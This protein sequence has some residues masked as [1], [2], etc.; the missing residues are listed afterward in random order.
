[1]IRLLIRNQWKQ[2][3]RNYTY[4]AKHNRARS[5]GGVIAYY[6]FFIF[7]MVVVLGGCFAMLSAQLAAPL[8][9]VGLGWL[10]YVLMGG[11]ALF[12]G[13]FGSVFNT[14]SSL[15][16]AKD[17]DLLLS[18]PIGVDAIMI[19][20]LLTVYLM[21]LMYSAVVLLP[22]LL[23]YWIFVS[24]SLRDLVGGLML[25][26]VISAIVLVL[27]C[28][29]GYLVARLSLKITNKGIVTAIA[30]LIFIFGYYFVYFRFNIWLREL[31]ANAEFYGEKISGSSRALWLFGRIGVGDPGAIALYL[32]VTAALCALTWLL[33]RRSFLKI[34]TSTGA[35][36]KAV[37]R[38]KRSQ[39][40]SLGAAL[41]S[42]E[43]RRFTASAN[44]MLNCGIG[45][46][47]IPLAGAALLWQGPRLLE[48]LSGIFGAE[49]AAVL[50]SV[51]LCMLVPMI[52]PA[53]PSVSLEGKNLW[54]VKS[55]PVP[56]WDV[57][58]AK[59]HL[60]LLC[61]A[62]MVFASLCVLWA[63]AKAQ[64]VPVGTA[65]LA[66]VLPLIFTVFMALWSLFWGV[67]TPNLGW[68][69]EIYPIKQS[70]PVTAAIL[71]G[72]LISMILGGVYLLL[73]SAL[74]ATVYLAA[75]AAVLALALLVLWRWL[76]TRGA[77]RFDAL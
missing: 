4:D 71:G 5:R 2:I 33:L 26:L 46:V 38:E 6:I 32:A 30:A 21:G 31:I 8:G 23:M 70:I 44:Y 19:S 77:A 68:T 67:L 36:K 27:S 15:Y 72:W 59:L 1:M 22:S 20:R 25:M 17:N 35:V 3:F 10:Y 34:A 55:L 75:A 42:R 29:L 48:A 52:D 28:V 51:M 12:L 56:A 24:F 64:L 62:P 58:R 63:L 53:A 40:R 11:I 9:S 13:I 16:L 7:I 57:L 47:F 74:S 73:G 69:N 18:L 39:L 54:L 60:Q 45:I 76:K 41:L 37:Y 14:F 43:T 65:L 50:I 61:C 49:S 66:A